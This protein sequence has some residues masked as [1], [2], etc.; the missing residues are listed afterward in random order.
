[1]ASESKAAAN[2]PK[3]M[4]NGP[5]AIANNPKA[6]ADDPEFEGFTVSG[7]TLYGVITEKR[8]ESTLYVWGGRK[9]FT[10]GVYRALGRKIHVKAHY[11]VQHEIILPQAGKQCK[12]ILQG[13]RPL[14]HM[15]R[16]MK[17]VLSYLLSSS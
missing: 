13:V 9:C 5:K 15:K 14:F 12:R 1:M 17:A 3:A 2:E 10:G 4:A 7:Y 6:R 11:A 8:K 16:G